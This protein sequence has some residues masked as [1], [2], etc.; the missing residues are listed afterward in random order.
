MKNSQDRPL[1]HILS[2]RTNI[3]EL[4]V[5]GF[6]IA[7]GTNIM[8]S[9]IIEFD[10]FKPNIFIYIGSSIVIISFLYLVLRLLKIRKF[11]KVIESSIIYHKNKNTLVN[12]PRYEYS[13]KMVRYF[14]YSFRE[15]KDIKAIWEKNKLNDLFQSDGNSVIKKGVNSKKLVKEA[16]EYLI[17]DILSTHLTDYFNNDE[18]DRKNIEKIER[19]KISD[20]IVKNRFLDLFSKPMSE[21]SGFLDEKSTSAENV[22]VSYRNGYYFNKFELVLPK[23]SKFLRSEDSTILIKNKRFSMKI[24]VIFDGYSNNN[25]P[26]SYIGYFNNLS[27]REYS[28]LS[29]LVQ[30]EVKFNLITFVSLLGWEYYKWIDSL[31]QKFDLVMSSEEFPK[32]INWSSNEVIL[33]YLDTR[34]PN[35][36]RGQY[37]NN[38]GKLDKGELK[39]KEL[40]VFHANVRNRKFGKIWE[41]LSEGTY[42]E[43]FLKTQLSESSIQKLLQYKVQGQL[44]KL[45]VL[46]VYY[47]DDNT[48]MAYKIELTDFIKE[49]GR[50]R[51]TFKQVQDT[52]IKSSDVLQVLGHKYSH[53]TDKPQFIVSIEYDMYQ[54]LEECSKVS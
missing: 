32:T 24:K 45:D 50:V 49:Q 40:F 4:I 23:K 41:E 53:K 47:N 38:G 26:Y 17:L 36:S 7:F 16:T 27:M 20:I 14:E 1:S 3:I 51:F 19:D 39:Q 15:N 18:L 46:G 35:Y 33:A 13:E 6:F 2:N 44:N 42:S 31:L 9:S 52:K 22:V 34:L 10:F 11:T 21:R 25:I 54:L 30:I 8:V 29:V 37:F 43:S 5:V 48:R 12:I 28:Q